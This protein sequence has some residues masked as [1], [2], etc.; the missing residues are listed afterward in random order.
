MVAF[1]D[2]VCFALPKRHVMPFKLIETGF[3]STCMLCM[4][5]TTLNNKQD[6]QLLQRDRAEGCVIV[7]AKSGRLELK[8]NILRT[9]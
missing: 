2:F 8:Y 7:L 1:C 3:K 6:A 5:N 9:L 4:F